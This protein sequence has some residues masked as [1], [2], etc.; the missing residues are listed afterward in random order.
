MALEIGTYVAGDLN[1]ASRGSNQMTRPKVD[2]V[3]NQT[4]G[5]NDKP[6]PITVAWQW[7]R[8]VWSAIASVKGWWPAMKAFVGRRGG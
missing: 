4:I 6:S 5:G 1:I 8:K 7:V 2:G 3:L